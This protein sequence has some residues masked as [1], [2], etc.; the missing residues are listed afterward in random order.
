MK[1]KKFDIET[2]FANV[3][4][5]IHATNFLYYVIEQASPVYFVQNIINIS[6]DIAHLEMWMDSEAE[7]RSEIN[8]LYNLY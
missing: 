8:R 1:T 2:T 4:D 5:S 7:Y 6:F 3:A